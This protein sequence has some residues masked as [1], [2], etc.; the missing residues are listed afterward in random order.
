MYMFAAVN[1]MKAMTE[2]FA[3]FDTECDNLLDYG[4]ERYPTEGDP[5]LAGVHMNIIY[6]DFFYVEAIL[7]MLDS[8]FM[9]W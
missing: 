4:T 7:K 6:G 3:N 9:I 2:K 8:D 5:K 1:L